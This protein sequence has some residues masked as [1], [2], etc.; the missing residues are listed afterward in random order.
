M[1]PTLSK[2]VSAL[3]PSATIAVSELANQLKA[4]GEAVISLALGEPDFMTPTFIQDA[5]VSAIR[6]GEHHYT[7]VGGTL[8]LKKAIIHKFA[9]DNDLHF[10]LDQV[11]A[12]T[13]CKQ[14][15][16]NALTAILDPEDEVII[17]APY[18]PSYPA[19]VSFCDAT[20]V[21]VDCDEQ[22]GFLMS[23]EALER[24]ITPQTK[25]VMINSPSNPTGACY[26]KSQLQDLLRVLES[27]PKIWVLSDEIYEHVV[28]KGFKQYSLAAL[29]DI[30]A[31]R[32]V[33]FNGVSKSH[34]MTGWRL[35]F[36]GGDADLIKAMSK[37]QSQSTSNPCSITQAAGVSALNANLDSVHAF[38]K[39]FAERIDYVVK[40]LSNTQLKISEPMGAFYIFIDIRA[41][42]QDD[43][44]FCKD[45]LNQEYLALV[46]GDAFGAKG[47]VR[48]SCAASMEILH[49][50]C[51][52][53]IHFLNSKYS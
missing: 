4:Q 26:S 19:M 41:Y 51:A 48:L 11:M 8:A 34:A 47:Y 43:V 13:G 21:I 22:D 1:Q 44:Q 17:H 29:N 15:I 12:G 20:P 40:T 36:C 50:A 5:A 31:P 18:W 14:V 3:K 7:P 42:T 6:N 30:V 16:F 53:I 35:G 9:R 46:P 25:A 10:N 32:V 23:P 28:Y 24:A 27:H 33:T 37:I 38:C 49:T 39:V 2:K 52:K 45:L